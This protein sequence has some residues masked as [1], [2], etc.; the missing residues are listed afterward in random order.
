MRSFGV[1]LWISAGTFSQEH[2]LGYMRCWC[3]INGNIMFFLKYCISCHGNNQVLKLMLK[4]N[5][6]TLTLCM[7]L[8]MLPLKQVI[9][10]LVINLMRGQFTDSKEV[11]NIN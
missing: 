7:S 2:E 5:A 6:A 3:N 10:C 1:Q 9:R 4:K 8:G 11:S